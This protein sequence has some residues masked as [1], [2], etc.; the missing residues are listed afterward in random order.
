MKNLT[1]DINGT[2]NIAC[3]FCYQ[4]LDGNELSKEDVLEIVRSKPDFDI[5]E[6]GGGEPL[7][8]RELADII[9]NIVSDGKKVHVSTNAT[10]IP[11]SLLDLE[12][13]VRSNVIM[14]VS[15]HACS[16]ERYKAVTGKDFFDSVISNARILKS[17]YTTVLNAVIYQKNFDQVREILKIGCG[18]GIPTRVSLVFPVGRGKSVERLLPEQVDRL[19]G[20][21]LVEKIMHPGMVDSPLLHEI[22]CPALSEAYGLERKG[23]CPLHVGRK[24]YVDPRGKRLGCEFYHRGN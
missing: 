19:R 10:F 8:H 7:L 13:S 17:L 22:N 5:V 12:E 4:D 6:I 1:I 14:Q 2:C 9:R 23:V 15:L 18:L 16:A 20:V 24:D 3:E 21:L 11:Q